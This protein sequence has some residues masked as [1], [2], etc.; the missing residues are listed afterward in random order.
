MPQQ[1]H[2]GNTANNTANPVDLVNDHG[3]K[4]NSSG[5][6]LVVMI[7]GIIRVKAS[8]CPSGFKKPFWVVVIKSRIIIG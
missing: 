8:L 4:T 1:H 2:S 7:Q 6:T 3:D 5:E